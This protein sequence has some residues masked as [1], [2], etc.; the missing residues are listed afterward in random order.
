[1][2]NL[3]RYL[4]MAM[5]WGVI[6]VPKLIMTFIIIWVGFRVIHKLNE[7]TSQVLTARKVDSTIKPFFASLV[8]VGLKFVLFLV[9]GSI[10]GFEISA[11]ITLVS[12]LAF[13]VGLALQGSLGHLAS[14]ILI[15]ILK[16][17][18]VGDE[19]KIGETEGH[20]DEIQ[21][22]ST[23]IRTRDNRRVFIPNGLVTSGTVT[24][25]SGQGTRRVDMTIIVDEPNSVKK[26]K[27]ALERAVGS[28]SMVLQSPAPEI[29]MDK[30][31]SNNLFF[32]V[33]PW[34][35]SENYWQVWG[36]IHEAIKIEFDKENLIGNV[37]YVQL[38]NK[39]ADVFDHEL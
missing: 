37:H 38:I 26:I 35:A 24:N 28:C 36:F 18:K 39:R 5:D 7:I 27:L 23:I 15:L 34:C 14:G 19:I 12:A 17:Y 31:D 4:Q 1:M 22:F 3:H 8:D 30:F 9:V 32:A 33:R 20:V 6:F 16:P 13:A 21:V 29:F 25:M 10:F 11:I 2:D